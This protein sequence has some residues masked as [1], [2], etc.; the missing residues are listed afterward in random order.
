MKKSLCE[1]QHEEMQQE[2]NATVQKKYYSTFTKFHLTILNLH[3][4]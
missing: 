3:V 4:M 1:I 2:T